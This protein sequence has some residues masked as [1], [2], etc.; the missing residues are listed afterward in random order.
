MDQFPI[1]SVSLSH[2]NGMHAVSSAGSIGYWHLTGS[3]ET[4]LRSQPNHAGSLNT[5]KSMSVSNL[6]TNQNHS[7]STNRKFVRSSN[8]KRLSIS[9]KSTVHCAEFL[10]SL[11]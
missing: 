7:I 11:F 9:S 5:N 1:Q 6:S 3:V 2:E 8:P 10:V 4:V